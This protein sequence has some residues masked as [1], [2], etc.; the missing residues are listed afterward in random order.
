MNMLNDNLTTEE[1][2][3]YLRLKTQTL[4][5]WRL[6]GRGPTFLKLGRRVI[7]QREALERF[8]SECQR[9]ST[10]D[11]GPQTSPTGVPTSSCRNPGSG[12]P[13]AGGAR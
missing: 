1:A 2:A 12:R 11:L 10:S 7:Y 4:E 9:T 8:M 13:R 5:A 6:S 3:K